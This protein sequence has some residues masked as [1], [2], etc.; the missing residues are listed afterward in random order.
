MD[1]IKVFS[2]T[3]VFVL[4]TGFLHAAGEENAR[5]WFSQGNTYYQQKEYGKAIESYQR[6]IET[7]FESGA[8]YYNMGNAYYKL[9]EVGKAR[10]YYER[11]RSFMEGDPDL[12]AN[13]ELLRLRMVDKI[14]EPPEF[15]LFVWWEALLDLYS[16]RLWS[17]ITV[18]LF[19]ISLITAGIWLYYRRRRMGD[20][21]K[22]LFVTTTVVFLLSSFIMSNKIYERENARFGVI[23]KPSVSVFSEPDEEGTEVFVL[24]EGTKFEVE[25]INEAWLQI[26]MRD[27]KTGWL[28]KEAI[29]VI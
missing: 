28:K 2:L 18:I 26:K 14:E 13:L 3:L 15:I 21:Y 8:L 10:L 24:H 5:Q 27:G 19:W 6:V 20:R 9:N 17:W 16:I 25:R 23:L 12:K 7:G 22:M 1:K 11:A 29:A 4:M